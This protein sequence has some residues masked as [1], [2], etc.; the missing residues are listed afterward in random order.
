MNKRKTVNIRVHGLQRW[1]AKVAASKLDDPIHKLVDRL[2]AVM[3]TVKP[4]LTS[5]PDAVRAVAEA[6][7]E[8]RAKEKEAGK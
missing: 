8:C 7:K 6:D 5:D 3:A 1:T 4:E 2:F